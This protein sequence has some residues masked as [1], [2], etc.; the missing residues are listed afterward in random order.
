MV[1]HADD[2]ITRTDAKQNLGNGR[3]DRDDPLGCLINRDRTAGCVIE[4]NRITCNGQE[5]KE[6]S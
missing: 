1:R 5:G 2:G 4:R 3:N 6:S